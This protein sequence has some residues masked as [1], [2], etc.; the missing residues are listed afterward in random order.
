MKKLVLLGDSIRLIGYGKRVSE[1]LGEEFETWQPEENC[2]F[3]KYTLRMLFDYRDKIEGADVIH[4]NCGL[5]DICKIFPDGEPFT[6]EAEYAENLKR[7]AR[8]LKTYGRRVIFSTTT[9]CAEA[10]I[11]NKNDVIRRYNAV[12][13][14]ALAETGVMINDLY[15]VVAADI[16]KYICDD[17][18]HLSPEG[19][20]AAADSVAAAIRQAAQK[21][22]FCLGDSLT[23]GDYGIPG[24]RGIANVHSENYPHF[25]SKLTGAEVF[26]F[27]KCGYNATS[28]LNFINE[29]GIDKSGADLIILMLGSNG[30]MDIDAKTPGCDDYEAII[31]TVQARE[32]WAKIVLCTPPKATENPDYSNCGY[33]PGNIIP[34]QKAVRAIA[35]KRKLPLIDL[36]NSESFCEATVAKYQSN[37][38]LHFNREGY[39]RLAEII[40]ENLKELCPDIF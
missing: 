22:I 3:A 39:I 8:I 34:A 17:Q 21:R 2:R 38:G 25:L 33:M 29:G 4:F 12:A 10:N 9:P 23:E 13:V 30:G 27:G 36:F 40:C 5:W 37:D 11:H 26:N 31:E 24:K 32:P 7:I 14:K 6:S 19:I 28:F 35:E 20:A 1:L 15:S 18:I 16:S